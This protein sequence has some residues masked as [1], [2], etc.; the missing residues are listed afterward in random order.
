[1]TPSSRGAVAPRSHAARTSAWKPRSVLRR[2]NTSNTRAPPL[3]T[4]VV[5]LVQVTDSPASGTL[6]VRPSASVQLSERSANASERFTYGPPAAESTTLDAQLAL[7]WRRREVADAEGHVVVRLLGLDDADAAVGRDDQLAHVVADVAGEVA[8]ARL[9]GAGVE[10]ADRGLLA[11]ALAGEL[12]DE[13]GLAGALADHGEAAVAGLGRVQRRRA[14]R[15]RAAGEPLAVEPAVLE[16]ADAVVL[17]DGAAGATR[18]LALRG[19]GR[20]RDDT[21]AGQ[22]Q[23]EEPLHHAT[24]AG[25]MAP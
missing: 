2:G 5:P 23:E 19:V 16:H 3:E 1:M 15:A 17:V 9:R 18:V 6:R 21:R 10:P 7:A 14:A 13:Q 11:A 20:G 24:V 4:S 25:L 22:Y 12:G 8:A